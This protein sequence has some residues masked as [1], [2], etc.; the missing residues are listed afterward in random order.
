[1]ILSIDGLEVIF[2]YPTVYKEQV[3]F[4]HYYKHILDNGSA[5][6]HIGMIEMPSG[7]GKTAAILSVALAYLFHHPE[8]YKKIYYTTRTISQIEQIMRELRRC[9]KGRIE[10][11]TQIE[12]ES[13]GRRLLNPHGTPLSA[14]DRDLFAVALSSRKNLCINAA[15]TR[16]NVR[17]Y[18]KESNMIISTSS[19]SPSD[20]LGSSRSLP[21]STVD[22]RCSAL[23]SIN[24]RVKA[25]LNGL[26]NADIKLPTSLKDIED[27]AEGV[28]RHCPFFEFLVRSRDPPSLAL[29]RKRESEHHSRHMHRSIKKEEDDEESSDESS[30]PTEDEEVSV[31]KEKSSGGAYQSSKSLSSDI[32]MGKRRS[33]PTGSS[34]HDDTMKSKIGQDD[35]F[36]YPIHTYNLSAL[37][38]ACGSVGI[39]PY[40]T[41]RHSFYEA[42][43]VVCS[44]LYLL[45]P[46]LTED[47]E[48]IPKNS[49]VIFD[50]AHN[51]EGVCKEILSQHI[52]RRILS[53]SQVCL[54]ELSKRLDDKKIMA[55]A[56]AVSKTRKAVFGQ[57]RCDLSILNV[58]EQRVGRIPKVGEIPEQSTISEWQRSVLSLSSTPSPSPFSIG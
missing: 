8:R 16:R 54:D 24:S 46:T 21:A 50:E 29:K 7:T 4:M 35:G 10:H 1:M 19:L 47:I 11:Y 23:T 30:D 5:D 49:M 31:K 36:A 2:P 58:S 44:Y 34:I 28:T 25:N 20:Q 48:L 42:D 51:I 43:I 17:G 52:N 27:A 26:K 18:D 9:I 55:Y 12:A 40:H 13:P 37:R 53:A 6:K 14:F 3:S 22:C 41:A 57:G 15:V 33:I 39:C 56:K 38:T 45:D 32:S